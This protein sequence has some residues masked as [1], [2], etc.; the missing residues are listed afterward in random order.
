MAGLVC[1]AASIGQESHWLDNMCPLP[2]DDV[3]APTRQLFGDCHHPWVRFREVLH[4]A[5]D[6]HNNEVRL[7]GRLGDGESCRLG[8]PLSHAR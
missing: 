4:P 6:G 8:L 2:P 1:P 7:C 3:H 5:M